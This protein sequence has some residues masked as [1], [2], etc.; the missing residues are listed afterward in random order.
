MMGVKLRVK[1]S[2][3]TV[4]KL[5]TDHGGRASGF[6]LVIFSNSGRGHGL[7]QGEGNSRGLFV[8]LDEALI[9]DLYHRYPLLVTVEEGVLKGGFGSAVLE[10]LEAAG[11]RT[12]P[13]VCLGL[14]SEFITFDKR[15]S[16]LEK[17]GLTAHKIAD[18]IKGTLKN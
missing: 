5:G 18:T 1:G 6:V 4:G 11:R 14:P 7:D 15:K 17:Y 13:V 10:T 16:L 3:E 2:R 9:L 12:K 8:S